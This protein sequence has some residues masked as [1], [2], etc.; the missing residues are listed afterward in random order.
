MLHCKYVASS[1]SDSSI[2]LSGFQNNTLSSEAGEN[3]KTESRNITSKPPYR[4]FTTE[5]FIVHGE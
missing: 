1:R 2:I 5:S 3:Y 4:G